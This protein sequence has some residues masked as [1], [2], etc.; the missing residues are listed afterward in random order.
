MIE[1]PLQTHKKY[2]AIHAH[3]YQPPRENPWT[4][5][6]DMEP[7]AL[8]YHDWN[9]KI[10][11]ECYIP[12]YMARI[13]DPLARIVD[14]VNNY[15][16]LNFNFGPTLFVWL[17]KA[18]PDYYEKIIKTAKKT[19]QIT[20][21]SNAI[22]QPY[23]HIIMPL[24]NFQDQVT[25]ILWGIYDFEQ[26]FGFKPE[27]MWLPETAC[28]EDTLRLLIDHKMNYVILSPRQA[29]NIRL[30]GDKKW[31]DVSNGS[32]DP[33][34]PY[35]WFDVD[36]KG[37]I[38]K[39][40]KIAIFFYD[41]NLS[42]SVA[43][44]DAL[45]NSATFLKHILMCYDDSLKE[46]QLVSIVTDGETYGHH[47]KFGDMTL[48]H[49]FKTE[50]KKHGIEI[51]NFSSYL[52]KHP[53][54]YEVKIKSGIDG[55]GT[56][57]SC[58]HGL[59][60]W[61]GGC[62]CGKEGNFQLNWRMPLRAA[63]NWLR[64]VLIEIYREEGSPIFK[65]IWQARNNYIEVMLDRNNKTL[66][67]FWTENCK[68]NLNKEERTKALM[69]M[70]IQ[71]NSM[72]MFTSCGWFFSDIS[73]I[74]TVQNLKYAARAI[75]LVQR[76]GYKGIER[77]FVS[78]LE[79]AP[80]NFKEFQNGKHVY[81][82]LVKP[83]SMNLESMIAVYLIFYFKF[84]NQTNLYPGYEFQITETLTKNIV[85]NELVF[86]TILVKNTNIAEDVNY[87]FVLSEMQNEL[88][89]IYVS[90]M[91]IPNKL[92]KLKSIQTDEFAKILETSPIELNDLP[93]G[94]KIKIFTAFLNA[95]TEKH[96]FAYEKLLVEYF[97]IVQKFNR[98][99][100][101]LLKDLREGLRI[102]AEKVLYS[103]FNEFFKNGSDKILD[104]IY[105]LSKELNRHNLNVTSNRTELLVLSKIANLFN[106]F[107][108]VVAQFIKPDK[109]GLINQTPTF[110]KIVQIAKNLNFNDLIYHCQ[111]KIIEMMLEEEK[112]DFFIQSEI[113][114]EILEE[115]NISIK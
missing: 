23:N 82:K 75:E 32:I 108:I 42:Q 69:L 106:E 40:R 29:E 109:T 30:I 3:F 72:Y 90:G 19:K 66:D 57:W 94:E 111:N 36:S 92:E 87:L 28:N 63:L 110:I 56:S 60:R 97:A 68:A 89:Q 12:N 11:R 102:F 53:P 95:N 10:A 81:E 52:E 24:A 86:G 84:N 9:E 99:D 18:F 1:K 37:N 58:S 21:H 50:L 78:L 4:Q 96:K 100:F 13:H 76:L 17:E 77:G 73:R 51:I 49:S 33:K 43:F 85:S 55:E 16:Y 8:P 5:N 59:K 80:S 64:D 44:Q 70:E 2:L 101:N 34:K 22:A 62:E 39:D 74:E 104:E 47:H 14:V 54:K 25:Q 112:K 45:V 38:I 35:L 71:K 91:D 67:K 26:R 7:S 113:G 115:L 27:A 83:H 6:V 65:D 105:L 20:G 31:T 98:F 79:L 15:E 103:K 61:K 93:P 46:D 114:K 41:F 107:Q 48:A 88:P